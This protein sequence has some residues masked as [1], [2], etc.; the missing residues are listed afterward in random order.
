[1]NPEELIVIEDL[2]EE[3]LI[4]SENSAEE[5]PVAS[6]DSTEEV[7]DD[8]AIGTNLASI[9]YYSSELPFLNEFKSSSSWITQSQGT[10]NT[11]EEDMLDLDS[12]G[13]VRSLPSSEEG[14]EY[15]SVSTLLFRDHSSYLPGN[16]VVLYEGEGEIEYGFDAEKNEALSTPGRD[17]IEVEP[18]SSGILL[19]IT[20][21]DPD[22]TGDYIRD[23]EIVPE[24]LE[25]SVATET[26]NPEFVD[27]VERFDALRFMDWM[28]TN[29][30]SQENWEDRP[31]PEDARYVDGVPL[32]VMVELAN[33]TDTDPWFNIP[34]LATDEYVEN[35]AEYVS[36]NLDPD[37]NVYVEYSNE[38][39][40]GLFE[41]SKYA[42][43]Q[44]EQESPDS[45][46][47]GNDWYGKRT[48]EVVEIWEEAFAEDPERVVGVLSAQNA[49]V[50]IGE[51]ILEYNWSDDPSLSNSEAGIDAIAINPYFGR[52]I[53][54][55]ENEAEVESWLEE[56]DGGLDSLF[57]EI[58][59]G[60]V[61][62]DSPE[63]GA[64][65]E[66]KN[67]IR[68]YAELAEEENLS[69]L[70]YEGGQHLVG[71]RSVQNNQELTD[72][73]IEANSDPRMGE[74]YEEFLSL[75]SDAGGELFAHYND[76][77]APSKTGSWGSLE[78][79][80]QDGSPKYNA[81]TGYDP[82]TEMT[83]EPALME[84]PVSMEDSALV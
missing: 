34:H 80:Y 54:K 12:E 14:A 64:L 72:L 27:K 39:W 8:T 4:V 81:L 65:G 20:E 17:V 26:F 73:F 60:G 76:I 41:Q 61:L 38:V 43:Q 22:E 84:E 15:T 49:N 53:G 18:S 33:Q 57:Q 37:L 31:K 55:P 59:E 5:E 56:P 24:D 30:S 21:T 52:Y 79:V 7:Q 46:L 58:T 78:S 9:D 40:N 82:M 75:W 10:W 1:M 13:W 51:R 63:G 28:E 45:N 50:A 2:I 77:K 71:I 29:G 42:Q 23:I 74:A 62:S 44:A 6:E 19:T 48:V 83:E 25:S 67:N 70:G 36:E 11:K 16:Y 3:E 47:N 35:F 66:V 69:L 32:E 68:E